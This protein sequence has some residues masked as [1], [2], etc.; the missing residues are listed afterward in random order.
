MSEIPDIATKQEF[1]A[2]VGVTPSCV[3]QWIARGKISGDALVG[4]RGCRSS[5]RVEVAR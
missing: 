1:A 5:I 2:L 3:S 4:R